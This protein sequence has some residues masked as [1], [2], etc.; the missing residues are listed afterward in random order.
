[1]VPG[2]PISGGVDPAG[3]FPKAIAGRVHP[4]AED[5][6]REAESEGEAGEQSGHDRDQPTTGTGLL[7]AEATRLMEVPATTPRQYL[8]RPSL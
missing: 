4:T 2:A 6:D 3:P 5:R 1:V 7:G 8:G